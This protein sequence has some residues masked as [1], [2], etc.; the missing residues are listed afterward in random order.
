MYEQESSQWSP[1]MWVPG[2]GQAL[3]EPLYGQYYIQFSWP[4]GEGGTNT[5]P[6]LHIGKTEAQ[7]TELP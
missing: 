7:F 5:F 3:G 1:L 6:M 2:V 4:P